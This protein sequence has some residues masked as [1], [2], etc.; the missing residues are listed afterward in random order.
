MPGLLRGG[1]FG[2]ARFITVAP[3]VEEKTPGGTDEVP[4][5]SQTLLILR[6]CVG[7][8]PRFGGL[9]ARCAEQPGRRAEI[10]FGGRADEAHPH[11]VVGPI[12]GA[13]ARIEGRG[14]DG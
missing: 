1:R 13:R 14:T 4:S 3:R 7:Y 12:P 2:P 6:M 10:V 8:S 11:A 9:L 5:T